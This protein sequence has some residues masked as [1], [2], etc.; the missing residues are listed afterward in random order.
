MFTGI[1]E[2]KGLVSKKIPSTE[3]QRLEIEVP[4]GF[5]TVSYTHLTLPTNREV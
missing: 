2:A 3:G 4:E 1:V 5:N